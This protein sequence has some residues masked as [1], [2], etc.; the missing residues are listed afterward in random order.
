MILMLMNVCLIAQRKMLHKTQNMGKKMKVSKMSSH[1]Q[2]N[3]K[4]P[5]EL[6]LRLLLKI[7]QLMLFESKWHYNR[8]NH[9]LENRL[10][11]QGIEMTCWNG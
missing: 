9:Y 10:L 2:V 1:K 3:K 7:Q 11:G 5:L 8:F 4:D 6:F